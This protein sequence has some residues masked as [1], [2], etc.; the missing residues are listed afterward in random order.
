MGNRAVVQTV[1]LVFG[2]IYFVVG[3][4]GFIGPLIGTSSFIT[5]TQDKHTLLG[6]ADINLL[7]NLVH[8]LVGIAGLAAA[9]SVANSRSFCQV[10]GVILLILGILGVF[11][12]NLLGVL[13]LAGFDIPLHLVSGA[14]LAYFGFAATV[15]VRSRA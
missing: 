4:L 15:S 10:V 12:G 5:I 13:P 1:A 3:V 2:V 14:V 7:H 8:L 9:S 6:I 11:A